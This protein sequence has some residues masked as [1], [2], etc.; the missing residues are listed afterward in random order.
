MDEGMFFTLYIVC[1]QIQSK[2][3][4][5]LYILLQRLCKIDL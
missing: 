2:K 3:D 4:K 1:G 5:S